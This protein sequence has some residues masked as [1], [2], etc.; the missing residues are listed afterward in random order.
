MAA[1]DAAVHRLHTNRAAIDALQKTMRESAAAREKRAARGGQ[2][3]GNG[4]PSHALPSF[5]AR[6]ELVTM[7][8][9][10]SP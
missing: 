2:Q 9:H 10:S 6:R 7:R 8:S 4:Q 1:R 5:R 3:L